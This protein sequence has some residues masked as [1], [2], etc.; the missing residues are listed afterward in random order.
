MDARSRLVAAVAAASAL[1]R[2]SQRK[3]PRARDRRRRERERASV[4]NC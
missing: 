1:V 2:L 4:E 3:C